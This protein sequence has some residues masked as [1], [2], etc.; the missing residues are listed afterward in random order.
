[1]I[2]FRLRHLRLTIALGMTTVFTSGMVATLSAQEAEVPAI[3]PNTGL[4]P[5]PCRQ[6]TSS[7]VA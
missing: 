7:P 4:A 2:T 5:P 6:R 3:D 1:M